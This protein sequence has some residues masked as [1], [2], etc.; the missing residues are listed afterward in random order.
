MNEK[1]ILIDYQKLGSLFDQRVNYSTLNFNRAILSS[2]CRFVTSVPS[3]RKQFLVKLPLV[4][5]M[6]MMMVM[7]MV[8]SVPHRKQFSVKLALRAASIYQK[9]A[10]F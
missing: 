3:H 8:T 9:V 1:N 6:V 5:V 7:V 2:L 4:M 10:N